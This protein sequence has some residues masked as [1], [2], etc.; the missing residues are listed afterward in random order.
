MMPGLRSMI[1]AGVAAVSQYTGVVLALFVV[2]VLVSWG[3]GIIIMRILAEAFASSPLF[4]E[5][6]DGDLIALIQVTRDSAAV[7]GA[8]G[9]VAIG[10]V[11][12]WI[13]ISWFLAAGL[14]AV[15]TDRP[16][17]RLETARSSGAGGATHFLVFARLALISLVYHLPVLF[18]LGLGIE[19]IGSRFEYAL[20][21]RELIGPL[22]LGLLPAALG[23]V[24]VSTIIDYARAELVLRRPTHESLGAMRAAFRATGY[25][26]RR[27]VALAHVLL[28]WVAFAAISIGFA[29]LAHGHAMLGFSGAMALFALRH[30]VVLLRL[31]ARVAVVAGQVEL[32]ATRPP[33]PREV[34][35][36]PAEA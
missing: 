3:A 30:G 11:I 10:A 29:W 26:F 27:P 13:V 21:V 8:V 6:V 18:V 23:H 33:P 24:I 35:A 20:T 5:A 14:L 4:D 16:R 1:R 34:V 12:A 22:L 19:H 17:G 31:A 15:F 9:W 2:Q 28:Y 36:V 32:T 7:I 25:V